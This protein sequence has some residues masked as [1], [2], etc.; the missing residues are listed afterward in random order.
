HMYLGKLRSSLRMS[1]CTPVPGSDQGG[2]RQVGDGRWARQVGATKASPS[3]QDE[4]RVKG[5]A[6]V[7]PY[8]L[9]DGPVIDAAAVDVQRL[10]RLPVAHVEGVRDDPRARL[11][12]L[13]QLRHQLQV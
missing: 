10:L 8:L 5:D 4:V 3:P 13:H 12:L 9:L 2:K 7:A 11:E 6:C 1:E